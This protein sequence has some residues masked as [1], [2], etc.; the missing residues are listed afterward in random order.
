MARCR[1]TQ[2]ACQWVQ[3]SGVIMAYLTGQGTKPQSLSTGAARSEPHG[4]R[5][6]YPGRLVRYGMYAGEGW[7]AGCTRGV[8]GAWS[9]AGA[10][11][12]Q[13]EM[14]AYTEVLLT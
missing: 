10:R 3:I 1:V 12:A 13:G 8:E 4:A 14:S 2:G 7:P 5:G 6:R 11:T 9:V